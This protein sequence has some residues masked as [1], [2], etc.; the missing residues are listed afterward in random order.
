ME[1]V[2]VADTLQDGPVVLD[3]RH[4]ERLHVFLAQVLEELEAGAVEQVVARHGRCDE[5]EDG[6]KGVRVQE[7]AVV[8]FIL[9]ADCGAEE[10]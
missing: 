4:D 7:L 3:E 8:E 6:L 5:A 10:F 2:D 1:G 9:E